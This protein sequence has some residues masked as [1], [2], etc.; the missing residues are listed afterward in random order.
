MAEMVLNHV[1]QLLSLAQELGSQSIF[2]DLGSA[3]G[4]ERVQ[5]AATLAGEQQYHWRY[6][7]KF[8]ESAV[9]FEARFV[10]PSFVSICNNRV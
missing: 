6:I 7:S 5:V 8:D 1:S 2:W 10:E 9:Y 4:A 3:I